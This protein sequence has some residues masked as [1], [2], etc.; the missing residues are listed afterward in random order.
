[1]KKYIGI[2]IFAL[3]FGLTSCSDFLDKAPD[4]RVE[5]VNVDDVVMLLGTAY[6][7]ANYGWLC[8]ISSDNIIDVN[9]PYLSTQSSGNEIEV[10]FNLNSYGLED[11]EVLL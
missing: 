11:D 4:E 7:D 5:L 3:G 9:A 8:E 6:S 10:R 2:S 1:M